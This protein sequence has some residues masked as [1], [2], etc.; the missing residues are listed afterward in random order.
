MGEPEIMFPSQGVYRELLKLREEPA[1]VGQ[2]G[3][4]E[5]EQ[6]NPNHPDS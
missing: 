2:E 6:K 5:R 3:V 1:G 4:V